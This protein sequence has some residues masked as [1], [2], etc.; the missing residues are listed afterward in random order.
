MTKG[1]RH[2]AKQWLFF[3]AFRIRHNAW[4]FAFLRYPPD[5]EFQARN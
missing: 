4:A 2:R 1:P 5:V 3:G